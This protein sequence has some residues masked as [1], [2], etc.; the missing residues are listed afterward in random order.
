MPRIKETNK[1]RKARKK[2]KRNDESGEN[3][4]VSEEEW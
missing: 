1:I 3:E 4:D 2:I